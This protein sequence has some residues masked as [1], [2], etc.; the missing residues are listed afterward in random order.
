MLEKKLRIKKTDF[1]IIYKK[2]RSFGNDIFYIRYL[3]NRKDYSQFAIVISVK[4]EKS[5]VKRNWMRRV[6]RSEIKR[7][8]DKIPKGF[9]LVINL[10]KPLN[11]ENKEAKLKILLESLGKIRVSPYAIDNRR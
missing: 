11:S 10:K 7:N 1:N 6:A 9:Y 2:G 4:T 5:A 8:L 3:P